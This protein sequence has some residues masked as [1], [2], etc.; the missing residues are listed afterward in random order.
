MINLR[1]GSSIR[2]VAVLTA[3]AVAVVGGLLTVGGAFGS[4]SA[5][6]LPPPATKPPDV[7][8]PPGPVASPP[9]Q[10]GNAPRTENSAASG[11]LAADFG[12]FRRAARSGESAASRKAVIDG[13]AVTLTQRGD[14]LCISVGTPTACGPMSL[15]VK[16]PAVLAV[17]AVNGSDT[18]LYGYAGDDIAA[19]TVKTMNGRAQ[20]VSPSDNLYRVKTSSMVDGIEFAGSD[21]TKRTIVGAG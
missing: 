6:V 17:K 19:I 5:P 1:L 8:P 21:G 3:C 16:K 2:W 4:P 15:A 9:T 14:Q 18:T 11:A 12:V 20:T 10:P 7:L 13:A